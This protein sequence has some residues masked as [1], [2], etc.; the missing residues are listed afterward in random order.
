MIFIGF[1]FLMVF[2]KSH[3][4]TS[5]GFNF[6][7][8]AYALQI[9]IL[10][11]GYWH[12]LVVAGEW[13]K[14]TLDL[15]AL[16]IGDFGAGAVLITFGALLGKCSIHQLWVVATLEIIFYGLNEAIGAG[17]LMAVDMGG[18]MYVHTFGAYFGLAAAF[19]FSK[20]KAIKDVHG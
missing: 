7:I 8:A 12:M 20:E 14:I 6:L 4:W 3:S 13:H 9:S 1:G 10:I 5:I 19:F 16:I 17:L 18:S 15:P 2:L 11:T